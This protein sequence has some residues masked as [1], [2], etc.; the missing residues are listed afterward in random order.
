MIF[1][2]GLRKRGKQEVDKKNGE[3]CGG[4]A[5]FGGQQI[6]GNDGKR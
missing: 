5:R 6:G 3:G 4:E 1:R 2:E